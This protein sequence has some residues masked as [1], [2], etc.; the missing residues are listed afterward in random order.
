MTTRHMLI[1]GGVVAVGAYFLIF[2]GRAP[3]PA[4]VT[5][6]AKATAPRSVST[7]K[8]GVA[9]AQFGG[10]LVSSLDKLLASRKQDAVFGGS[11]GLT[12][13]YNPVTTEYGTNW[14]DV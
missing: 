13:D 5:G 1:G 6:A 8:L 12:P 10:A 4:S 14:G 7:Q 11:N 2:K 3:F 9:V